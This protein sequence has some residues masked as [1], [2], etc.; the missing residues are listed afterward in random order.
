L[1][2]L[3]RAAELRAA[4]DRA[5]R[6]VSHQDAWRVV[7]AARSRLAEIDPTESQTLVPAQGGGLSRLA[8]WEAGIPEPCDDRDGKCGP[9]VTEPD[10]VTVLPTVDENPEPAA[11]RAIE[12]AAVQFLRDECDALDIWDVP[13]VRPAGPFSATAPTSRIFLQAIDWQLL[14]ETDT[15]RAERLLT[16]FDPRPKPPRKGR[17]TPRTGFDGA[18]RLVVM[19]GDG[20][21]FTLEWPV[22]LGE[23]LVGLGPDLSDAVVRADAGHREGP[24][25]VWIELHDGR[26]VPLPS[27]ARWGPTHDYT[28]GYSG[29]GP[30]NLTA[31]VVDLAHLAARDLEQAPS[32]DAIAAVVQQLVSSGRTPAWTLRQI[33]T[34]AATAR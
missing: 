6:E 20:Q 15:H 12:R 3:P 27:H 11:V 21:E 16:L 2:D 1:P 18:G 23:D 31:A 30:S 26:M 22:G 7:G 24:Q 33:T 9:I 8:W 19:S 29:A 10:L 28:W 14:P 32:V 25:P 4:A 17:S 5:Q 13:A 34:D